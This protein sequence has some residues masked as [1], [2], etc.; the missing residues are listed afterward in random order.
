MYKFFKH[1]CAPDCGA[2]HRSDDLYQ[3][4]PTNLRDVAETLECELS[5]ALPLL[6]KLARTENCS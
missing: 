4:E 1:T 6:R 3:Y 2:D 5:A